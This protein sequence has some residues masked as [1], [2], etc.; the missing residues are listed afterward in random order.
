MATY[1]FSGI[2]KPALL[3][4]LAQHHAAGMVN[5]LSAGQPRLRQVYA[6]FH[7]RLALDSGA[8]QGNAD[9]EGYARLIKE[10]SPIVTFC[11][12]LDV[13]HNQWQSDEHFGYLQHLLADDEQ[14]C[15][16]VLWVYQCQS[17]GA[18]W[19]PQGDIDRL[20][21]ALER[22]TVVGIGGLV[23]ILERDLIEAQDVL[24]AL[25]GIL[26]EA[27]AQAHLFG[28]GS[29]P[30]LRWCLTQPWFRSADSA[31]WLRGLSS[32][33]LLTRDGQTLS[34][35]KLAFTGLQCAAHNVAVMQGWM[36]PDTGGAC[37][38]PSASSPPPSVQLQWLDD[39][40]ML[41]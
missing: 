19:H 25:G 40:L 6:S 4:V 39:A 17:R 38:F 22:H 15:R 29:Y 9:V 32:R 26:S 2:D 8:C 21:R 16:K 36:Q 23:S 31:R 28:L 7:Q 3:D 1:F 5:A 10:L 18:R 14:A 20:K 41:S 33:T 11:S 24:S 34:G 35:K 30:L 13:L 27:G 37:S 12:N